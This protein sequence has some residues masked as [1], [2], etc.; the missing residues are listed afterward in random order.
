VQAHS[1]DGASAAA[2]ASS[3]ATA[4]LSSTTNVAAAVSTAAVNSAASAAT[5]SLTSATKAVT[6]EWWEAGNILQNGDGKRDMTLVQMAQR[7]SGV[8]E[9]KKV[10]RGSF[11]TITKVG[12]AVSAE[13]SAVVSMAVAPVA[14][15]VATKLRVRQEARQSKQQSRKPDLRPDAAFIEEVRLIRAQLERRRRAYSWV[16]LPGVS[17]FLDRWDL[18]GVLMI[19][20]TALFT[21]VEVAFFKSFDDISAWY[22]AA[23][24]RSARSSCATSRAFRRSAMLASYSLTTHSY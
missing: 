14:P 18:L 6:S 8:N 12:T 3:V 9:L 2:A 1:V 20:Y 11:E 17:V 19:G 4:S 10:T 13:T 15:T 23:L 21:P 5:A 16:L 24:T 7:A 22:A